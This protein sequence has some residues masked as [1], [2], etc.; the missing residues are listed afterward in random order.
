MIAKR[1][2]EVPMSV[3]TRLIL[4]VE[5]ARPV[6][7]FV[8]CVGLSAVAAVYGASLLVEYPLVAKVLFGAVATFAG[9]GGLWF[10]WMLADGIDLVCCRYRI[11]RL[12]PIEYTPGPK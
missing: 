6:L 8:A 5:V 10:F 7:Y 2:T 4:W 3:R 11:R 12:P 1:E 9:L